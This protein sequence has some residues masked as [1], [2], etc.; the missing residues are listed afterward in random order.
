MSCYHHSGKNVYAD[1]QDMPKTRVKVVPSTRQCHIPGLLFVIRFEKKDSE[2]FHDWL[3]LLLLL[4]N[5]RKRLRMIQRSAWKLG[6][7]H[8][9]DDGVVVCCCHCRDH[10]KRLRTIQRSACACIWKRVGSLMDAPRSKFC[11]CSCWAGNHIKSFV[12]VY[13]QRHRWAPKTM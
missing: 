8:I 1:E 5:H 7:W 10:R 3:V 9:T 12:L 2:L 4:L 13:K 6:H 11:W